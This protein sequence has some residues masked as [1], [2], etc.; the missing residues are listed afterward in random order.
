LQE[1]NAIKQGIVVERCYNR[2]RTVVL[3]LIYQTKKVVGNP[4]RIS[5]N[6]QHYSG[7]IC[8]SYNGD[9]G[10]VKN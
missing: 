1:L 2:S 6:E 10:K 4:G 8:K 7:S 9:M 5:R 3:L